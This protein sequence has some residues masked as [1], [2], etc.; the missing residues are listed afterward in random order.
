M[1]FGLQIVGPR[2]GDAAVLA[3]ARALE[4]T[5]ADNPQTARPSPNLTHLKSAPA[6]NTSPGFLGF[7]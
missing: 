3:I 4:Q 7:G 2:G 6:L 1:P 5:L